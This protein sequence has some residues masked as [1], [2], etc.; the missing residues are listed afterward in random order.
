MAP[1]CGGGRRRARPG[2]RAPLAHQLR[3]DLVVDDCLRQLVAV[4]GQ[5][6]QRHRCGLL[7]AAQAGRADERRRER[8]AWRV[9]AAAAAARAGCA[10]CGNCAVAAGGTCSTACGCRERRVR[11]RAGAARAAPHLGTLSSSS[12]RS[13]AMAPACCSASMFC[14]RPGRV[15]KAPGPHRRRLPGP[16]ANAMPARAPRRAGA[17][18]PRGPPAR[19]GVLRHLRHR[20]HEGHALLLVGFKHL[21]HRA[22]RHGCVAR[23]GGGRA[24]RVEALRAIGVWRGRRRRQRLA[25]AARRRARRARRV[26]PAAVPC[27]QGAA[28]APCTLAH[29]P[30]ERAGSCVGQ[31]PPPGRARRRA[32]PAGAAAAA[33]LP[34]R[35]G[36]HGLNREHG[37]RAP[38]LAGPRA[39][40]RRRR[41]SGRASSP[42]ARS[43]RAPPAREP[44]GRAG[45]AAQL[46]SGRSAARPG[47]ASQRGRCAA[48]AG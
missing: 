34:R 20:R 6:A 39:P 33:V 43:G 8:R 44:P 15:F 19:L 21:Q 47:P 45:R 12:G 23:P 5:P 30:Q 3:Q 7:Y 46:S 29:G 35:P 17:S 28:A 24:R 11:T 1:A 48:M 18:R 10:G 36:L 27:R 22:R 2:H 38:A 41:G 32:R 26:C 40:P 42:A 37:P 14:G 16:V 9:A 31:G 4:V 13:R 25:A